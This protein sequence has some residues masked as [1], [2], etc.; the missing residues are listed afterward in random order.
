MQLADQGVPGR[1]ISE[2]EGVVGV[3]PD[4]ALDDLGPAGAATPS[5]TRR[6]HQ[7]GES[8]KSA[9]PAVLSAPLLRTQFAAFRARSAERLRK[10]LFLTLSSCGVV[11]TNTTEYTEVV[12]VDVWYPWKTINFA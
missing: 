12:A 1:H 3:H 2:L 6:G 9:P 5:G 10:L 4:L 11:V 8:Q 7:P